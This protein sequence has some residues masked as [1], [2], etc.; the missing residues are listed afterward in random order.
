[1]AL[2]HGE[3]FEAPGPMVLAR[4]A[5]GDLV[6]VCRNDE[7]FWVKVT[8]VQGDVLTATVDNDLFRNDDLPYGRA[9]FIE[10]RH[11]YNYIFESDFPQYRRE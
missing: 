10:R 9:V 2:L 3:T 6:K 5:P 7:R 8:N 11:I 1:M 4:I